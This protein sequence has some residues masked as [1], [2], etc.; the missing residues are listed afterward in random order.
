MKLWRAIRKDEEARGLELTREPDAGF[1]ERAY[2]WASGAPLENVMGEDDAPGD[3]VRTTKQLVDLLRQLE[4]IVDD[5]ELRAAVLEALQG[6]NRGVVAY[7]S[8]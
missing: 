4:D 7:S 3:F 8:L 5:A 1:V 6:V 2:L